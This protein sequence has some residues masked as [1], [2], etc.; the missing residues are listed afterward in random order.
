[1]AYYPE[2]DL[3]VAGGTDRFINLYENG[4]ES[5]LKAKYRSLD[6]SCGSKIV[7]QGSSIINSLC[8][9]DG[10]KLIV[11]QSD[12]EIK[13]YS[14]QRAGGGQSQSL[15]Q[16]ISK[17]H[18]GESGVSNLCSLNDQNLFISSG[19]NRSISVW[20]TRQS[21]P[22]L[23]FKDIHYD[24][25]TSIDKF[26]SQIFA[27]ASDDGFVNIWDLRMGEFVK[28]LRVEGNQR[29]SKIKFVNSSSAPRD[30]SPM[31]P[32]AASEFL[33]VAH[34]NQLSVLSSKDNFT[35]RVTF[36]ITG[37]ADYYGEESELRLHQVQSD[38]H[39]NLNTPVDKV[40]QG[41]G[42]ILDDQRNLAINQLDYSQQDQ[43][44]YLGVKSC[45]DSALSPSVNTISVWNIDFSKLF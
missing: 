1:M 24:T 37:E 38:W 35:R 15:D 21:Q 3:L 6:Y 18:F 5:S 44:L 17:Y 31:Q 9:I 8:A 45:R 19:F 33:V 16:P 23:F 30:Q 36:Q 27:S 25:I 7:K 11:G 2:Y 41:V 22:I 10:D 13:L 42:S 20:D 43:S 29:I 4:Q 39:T 12:E 32:S 40:P 34:S 14:L 26:N 28:Q